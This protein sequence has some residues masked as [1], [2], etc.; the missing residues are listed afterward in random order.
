MRKYATT[1]KIA[2]L[3]ASAVILFQVI[4]LFAVYQYIRLDLYLS[5]VAAC[6]LTTG[7]LIARRPSVA[8]APKPVDNPAP[9]LQTLLTQRELQILQLIVD[10]K[11]NKEI[12]A[13]HFVEVST[14]KTHINNIY[15]KLAVT[16]RV[17]ARLK[18]AEMAGKLA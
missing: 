2:L 6:F 11:T 3:T 13:V 4:S 16:N 1:V 8:P 12:A 7:M 5:L 15:T 18:Y 17:E 9:S 10:G 14:V